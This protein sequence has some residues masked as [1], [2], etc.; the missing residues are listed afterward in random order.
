[1]LTFFALIDRASKGAREGLPAGTTNGTK[2]AQALGPKPKAAKR[3]AEK[4]KR[5]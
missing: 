3:R 4:T 1:M 5:R 2:P